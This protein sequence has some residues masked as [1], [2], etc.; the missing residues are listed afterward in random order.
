M[1]TH[2][3]QGVEVPALGFGTFKLTGEDATRAVATAL[4]VGYRHIDTAEMYGNEAEVGAGLASG[5]VP[6]EDIFLTTKVWPNNLRPDDLGRALAQSLDKLRTDYLDLYLVHWPNPE[7]PLADT[8]AAMQEAQA[9]G[10]IR[11]FGVSNFPVA[12]MREAVEKIG[13][14]VFCN[15]VEYHPFLNQTPVLDY[16]RAHDILITSYCPLARGSVQDNAVLKRIGERH[17]KT[18]SQ[19]TLRW[20]IQQDGVAAIPKSGTPANIRSNFDIFDFALSTDEMAEIG[21]LRGGG[22]LVDPATAPAWD[23]APAIA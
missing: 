14:P 6:R 17:G 22:R 11:R 1:I 10:K 7:I 16:A 3:I 8:L 2:T 12:L 9:A 15:Q 5:S 19:V 23:P 13:A 20:H 4:D 18:A 21:N